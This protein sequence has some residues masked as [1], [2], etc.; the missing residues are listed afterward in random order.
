[1]TRFIHKHTPASKRTQLLLGSALT[2]SV[3]LAATG[4]R[5]EETEC[6]EA[7]LPQPEGCQ[8][9][10]SNVVVD[11]PI[12]KNTELGTVFSNDN[13]DATGFSISID[14]ERVAGSTSPVNPRRT[15]D[16]AAAQANV[17]IR[18][19]GLEQQRLLNITTSNLRSGFQA[20]E[21]ITL[22]ASANYP[23]Y[24]NRAEV[25]IADRA[26]RDRRVIVTLPVEPNGSANWQMPADGSGDYAYVLRVYDDRGRYDETM[27]L[28]LT[29]THENFDT[30]ATTNGPVIAAG[31]GE[32]RTRLR[33]IPLRGGRILA[34]GT[35][36]A[37]GTTVRVMGV[38]VSVDASGSFVTSRIAPAGDHVV[39]VE[40]EQGGNR[41]VVRRDVVI[42]K[43]EW[44]HVA[45]ADVTLG[46]RLQDDLASANPDYDANY[47]DGR[48][49]YYVDGRT[50]SGLSITSSLDTGEGDISEMFRRLDE[51]D[52]RHVI[53]RLDPED[54]YPTYGDDSSAY[55]NT[56][57]S[58][59]FYLRVEN[60]T[61]RLTW[62]DFRADVSGTELLAQSR[63]LYGAELRH[64]TASTT[65]RGDPLAQVV[66][67]AAQP[68]TLP[69]RDILR[70]TGG[71]VYFL[72]HQ[73]INGGSEQLQI[74]SIDPVTGRVIDTKR[75]IEG[76]DYEIDYIQGVALLTNPLNSSAN[77]GGLIGGSTGSY[78]VNLV[79]LY[80]YTPGAASL[81]GASYGGRAEVMVNDNLRLGVSASSDD[82]GTADQETIG[83]DLRY[84]LGD[85]SYI[86]AE[87]AQ[88]EGPGFGR[89][90][91]T[92][93][94]LSIDP[95]AVGTGQRARALRLEGRFD[96]QDLGRERSGNLDVWYERK[97]DGF[98]TL[99][100]DITQ[101]QTLFGF[102]TELE[103]SDRLS[104]GADFEQFNRSGGDQLTEVEARLTWEI[105][106][107]WTVA[108]GIAHEDRTT[109][110][111]AAK[112]GERTTLGLNLSYALHDNLTVYGFGE[113][114]ISRSGGLADDNRIGLGVDAQVT[115]KLGIGAEISG[116]DQ[117]LGGSL[118]LR[119][120]A[121]AD[122]E[123]YLGYTLDPTR[124]GAG[125][126]LV[127][128]DRGVIVFGGKYRHSETLSTYMENT[129]DLFGERRNLTRAFGVNYTPSA[130]WTYSGSVELGDVRDSI[131]GD[132]ERRAFSAGVAYTNE[133]EESARLR[134]E[135][136]TEDGA[137]IAQDRDTW[138]LSA[139]YENRASNDWRF[140]A[141]VDALYSDA[142]ESD[143]RNGEYLEASLGY[144]YRPVDNERLNMLFRY[145][146]LHDLP[147]VDQVTVSGSANG[148]QQ[149]SHILSLDANYDLSPRLTFGG[150]YGYRNSELTDRTTG[151]STAS[152]AHLGILRLDWHV[153]H[154]WDLLAEGRMLYTEQTNTSETGALFGLY[155]HINN[156][157]K[158]GLGYEWG[159]V[160]DDIADINYTNRGVFVNLIAKF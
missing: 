65:Q 5:A 56:P 143:F 158:L 118:R 63:E 69:Q 109:I 27:P 104:F 149:R 81:D 117:G 25:R 122:N 17:D 134:V 132:F 85:H 82:T 76:V 77:D 71:S 72:S 44:F 68:D 14:N 155:R 128:E 29:R 91:S 1:M 94:G 11:M 126:T 12:G 3:M 131:N 87:I 31:E 40:L 49:A 129:W 60:D 64:V 37:P 152:T 135:Y 41:R 111:D 133:D 28:T 80:E 138:A 120:A 160:S 88:T 137:G 112:T 97:E 52:S 98:S 45:I 2:A 6:L 114:A 67:Y 148:P 144:A 150:K 99:N 21:V 62:G 22:R 30:H 101:D 26:A 74:Q 4:L 107:R 66:I 127:G 9:A 75:L 32:D 47:V 33:N 100:E 123:V 95:V 156:N 125:Y 58:G 84:D 8:R 115:E 38:E 105:N 10:N 57:T 145:T 96:L 46:R 103:L 92:D 89:S 50:Q 19:D 54:L 130:R 59:R 42:P 70:G 113:A 154:K 93:G 24:I 15:Q 90:V 36:V 23:A 102:N 18:Y 121:T 13:F 34:H 119:Y 48:L 55:D 39:D 108:T 153:V 106:E 35:G 142:A 20:G 141:N 51:K 53:E 86:E 139:G 159:Q 147:G 43:S 116:G 61:T 157:V 73:D 83:L 7:M 146:Y 78:D 151:V 16:I 140:L 110:G 124:T 79:A 136:R